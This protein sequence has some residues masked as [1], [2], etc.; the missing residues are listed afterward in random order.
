MTPGY[1]VT[2]TDTGVG[3]TI[4]S[5][6]LLLALQRQGLRTGYMKPVQT[7]CLQQGP[8]RSAPDLDWVR[9]A[10]GLTAG[11]QDEPDRCPYRFA[12][13]ASPHLAAAREGAAIELD[14]IVQAYRRLRARDETLVVEG[15]GG[16]LV[17]LNDHQTLLDL[18]TALDLPV[19]VTARTGLGTINHTLLTLQA[20]RAAGLT[21][22][23][24]V[25]VE[26]RD[27]A[28]EGEI[29]RDNRLVLER[30]GAVP[31]WGRI[32][33]HPALAAGRPA[34]EPVVAAAAALH[35]PAPETRS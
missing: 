15:A 22:A 11:A 32:G 6:C 21:A 19:V 26:S 28:T 33:F 18:M 27:H 1:F 4:V 34:P 20:L 30:R 10:T 9:D 35:I 16:V 17:P 7:G 14:R 29:E 8:H 13:P 24:L 5:A 3:K 31:V 23:G 12:L 25:L 2:G